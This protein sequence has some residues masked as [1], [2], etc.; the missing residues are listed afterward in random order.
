MNH[1]IEDLIES[2]IDNIIKEKNIYHVGKVVRINSF[3]IEATGLEDAF[4]FEKVFI[5]N[6]ENIGYVDKIE[7]NKVIIALVKTNGQI[8]VGDLIKT[9]G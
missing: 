9:T 8:K 6:E 5:G 1:N 7:E 2:K 3:V 4:F